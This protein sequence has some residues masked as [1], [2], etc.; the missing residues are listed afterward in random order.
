MS[1]KLYTK[2]HRGDIRY[3]K[4]QEEGLMHL[5]KQKKSMLLLPTGLGKTLTS[6][7][8][9]ALL[10]HNNNENKKCIFVSTKSVV[11]QVHNDINKFFNG[12]SYVHLFE[13]PKPKRI[14]KYDQFDKETDILIISY[15]NIR[16]DYQHIFKLAKKHNPFIIWDE[17]TAF[18]NDQTKVYKL[19]NA[20]SRVTTRSTVLTATA[21][22]NKLQDIVNIANAIGIDIITTTKLQ[23]YY[24][25][26]ETKHFGR[27]KVREV[28]GY[29]NI[30]KFYE[31]MKPFIF[32]RKKSEVNDIPPFTLNKTFIQRDKNV[33]EAHDALKERFKA[34]DENGNPEYDDNGEQKYKLPPV[35]LYAIASACPSLVLEDE[36]K[37]VKFDT[38]LSKIEYD[39]DEN[40]K[41]IL[42]C[43]Y[44]SVLLQLERLLQI[45]YGTHTTASIHGGT[46]NRQAEKERFIEK[47]EC[48]FF[49]GTSAMSHGVDGL[50]V[51][52]NIFF[53]IPPSTSDILQQVAGRISRLNTTHTT[54]SLYFFF[55]KNS[56][57]Y[58]L[59]SMIQNQLVLINSINPDGIDEGLIDEDVTSIGFKTMEEGD[60]WIKS[61]MRMHFD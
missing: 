53:V 21:I 36:S 16:S 1:D 41:I 43:E 35:G 22:T 26:W 30:S 58:E 54:L 42:F 5:I 27:R 15:D 50:Q 56:I 6:L 4:H 52:N 37:S 39:V 10:K 29:K 44:K 45:T 40:E 25:K 9:Y 31:T 24:C 60:E 59:Y 38:I 12:I 19:V 17:G 13:D 55:M 20:I 18:K 51:A 57:D 11:G 28:I 23:R 61:R 48:R 34:V 49:L 47:P 32:S 3:Y 7:S 14:K 8:L 33:D 2:Y 46:K